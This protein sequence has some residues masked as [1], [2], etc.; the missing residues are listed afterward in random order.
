[1]KDPDVDFDVVAPARIFEVSAVA[2]DLDGTL[3]DTIHDLAAA[4]N[5]LFA[6][7][8]LPP[9]P[10][11]ILRAMVGKGM[12]NLVRRALAHTI[13]VSPEAIEDGEVRDALARYQAHYA[14]LLGRETLPFP[15]MIEGLDR[16]AAMGFPL[17]VVT[18]KAT[19][20]VWPHLERAHIAHYF[21]LA[22]GGDDLP[23]RKPDPAQ[24]LHVAAM[25]KVP[26]SRLLMVGDSGNDAK[27]ARAAG[28]PVL[29]L[30]Y[31]Y[32]EGEPV[33]NLDADGIVPSLVAVADRV[34]YVSPDPA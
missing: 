21:T 11:D 30:P 6:D 27:A 29:I 28:C 9:V 1:M 24:L 5:A 14:A 22:V 12:G 31:G 13:G 4:V 3:L 2:F 7:L 19:R 8:D 15:G 16:L 18:N 26:A 20:F 34:R 32:N 33:Q 25:L 10:K 17:A 23:T